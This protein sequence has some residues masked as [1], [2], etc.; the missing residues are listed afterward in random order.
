MDTLIK[1]LTIIDGT[2]NPSF[3]GAI[4]MENGKL[5]VFNEPDPSVPAKE[6]IDGTGLTAVPGFI[7]AHSHG[8]LTMVSD[9][10]TA[11]KITQG[12]TTQITG[13]CSFSMFPC[14]PDR[15]SYDRFTKFIGGIAPYPD[16]PEDP[17]CCESAGAFLEWI[18]SLD[19]PVKTYSL[20]GH[21]SLRLWAM[22]YEDRKPDSTE[23]KRMQDMLRRCIREGALG[24]STGLVYAPSRCADNEELLALLRVVHEEGGVYATHPR[25]EADMVVEARRESIRLVQEADVPLCYSHMKT[26]GR[27]NWGK[28][29]VLLDDVNRA[30]DSG[31]KI[32]MDNYPYFAGNTALNVSIPPRYFADGL[33]GLVRALQDPAECEKIEEE[34]SRK[35][36]YDNYIYNAGGFSGTF[37]SSCPEFHDAENMFITEYAE[38]IGVSPFEAYRRI[39]VN[40]N[41][42]GLGIYFH[43]N[44]DDVYRIYSHPLCAVG[45]DGLIGLS[46]E[47]PHPRSFG[48]MPRA[49][50]LLTEE[51]RLCSPEEAIH[52][53]TGLTAEFLHLDGKGFLKD[54]KDADVLLLDMDNFK[55]NAEYKKGNARCSGI[56]RVF[57]GGKEVNMERYL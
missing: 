18:C 41:G 10:A 26:A 21:G 44:K 29:T 37:V 53:M 13:Q 2:G 9:Y 54:G 20:V 6:V 8:D 40:N 14:D 23:L 25:N 7:D 12:I 50:R 35:S 22:G 11:S 42:L 3:P 36:N 15:N 24:L 45:T 5:T 34:M 31:T 49:Y 55:D 38:K 32:L 33:P 51:A 30:L 48:T 47:N 43:L 46:S 19:N 1:C 28:S 4:G 27:D 57:V 52:R 56:S 16:M 39:L 17:A